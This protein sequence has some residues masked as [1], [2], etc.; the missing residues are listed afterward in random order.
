MAGETGGFNLGNAYGSVVIDVS[1]VTSAMR[2]AKDAIDRGLS[3]VGSAISSIGD[4]MSKL[5]GAI[6]TFSAPLA[7][8]GG[9]G[10]KAAA[11]F[12]TLMKQI[13]IFGNVAPSQMEKVSQFALK[14]GA[15]TKFS[16]ADAAAALLEL[17][18]S[19][20]SL[21]QAMQT[22]PDV[23]NLAATGNLDL[24][25][26][27]GIVSSALAIF[28]LKASDA[29]RVSNALAQAANATRA[30]VGDLGQGLSNVGPVA[31]QFGLSIE[32]TSAILG[33]FANN[34][35]MGAEAG[36][37]LK[38]MLLNMSRPTEKVQ[39]AFHALG[40]SLY[41][42]NGNAR[43]FNTVIK[44]LD[45]ALSKLPVEQ[46]N[47]LMQDLA[48][49]YG[50][51][52]L[53]ALRAAGGIDAT[54]EAMKNAPSAAKVAEA[55]MGTFK[56]QVES[57]TGSFETLMISAMT[58]FM[59][60]V[61]TPMVKQVI[62]VVNAMTEWTQK[63]PDLTKQ[64]VKVLGVVAV[65][66]P[67]LLV[68]GKAFSAIGTIIT[69]ATGPIGIIGALLYGLYQAFQTNFL[70]IRDTLQPIIDN[71][72]MGFETLIGVIG[73][74][75]DLVRD[76]GIGDAIGFIVNAFMQMLGLVKNDELSPAALS[77]GNGIVSAF[78]SVVGFITG[79]VLPTLGMVANWFINDALPAV[80]A[81]VQ[82]IA[83]PG[84]GA[85]FKF[86]GDIWAIVGPVLERLA[87][88][89]INDALPAVVGFIQNTVIPGIQNFINILL[90]VWNDVSPF[91]E[92]LANWFIND[93]LP[94]V[95]HYIED[96]VIVGI[97]KFID[98]L[99]GIW[100]LVKPTLDTLYNWFITEG[101][102]FINDALKGVVDNFIKPFVDVLAGIWVIVDPVLS[103]LKD[104]FVKDGL[105][106]ITTF[107]NDF[108]NN[109]ITPVI[110]VLKGIWD[111]V[112][113]ALDNLFKWFRDTFT[114]IKG[115]IQ[116]VLDFINDLIS[117]VT[118]AI[119]QLRQLGGGTPN[120]TSAQI[121]QNGLPANLPTIPGRDI[122]G[123]GMAGM[124]YQIGSGQLKNEVYIPGADGQ[125]VSGFVDLMKQVAASVGGQGSG[126]GDTF[127]IMMPEGALAN[128]ATARATGED[129]GRGVADGMRARGVKPL[130]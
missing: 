78:Q 96:V 54:L 39:D 87:N 63:N 83:I 98:V 84:I 114:Q 91:L 110:N 107:L 65:L 36:T 77:M 43:N 51:T 12:D 23:L 118:T 18:K 75:G 29:G 33:V 4:Q 105:P 47:M 53:N 22:L 19:G 70:G 73:H 46:Q 88:W 21:D 17:L 68:A 35:I 100:D 122:G 85:L 121:V 26:A 106:G 113:P 74:F 124:Q 128:P 102:P 72:V 20:Q 92:K 115:F 101:L 81:F 126:G 119:D 67:A 49:S 103:Q 58:P 62:E 129:F 97:Q 61:L 60:D 1:G 15:D 40:V 127:N 95:V 34:G 71:V 57:L 108:K 52:G 117:K 14:M 7:A 32:D 120:Q 93:V 125:F 44:E 130:R 89:F 116:P 27:S 48:G 45:S 111:A 9:I 104:W 50:I 3:G 94:V 31:A 69:I 16:S 41:D 42:S 37:Q 56:G 28:K 64:I 11:D 82:N 123:P 30:D 66:G 8:A 86:L 90:K 99:K 79:T 109:V 5:G 112:R 38:S 2:Q 76:N 24:A 6:S 25:R 80:V 59:N 10:L 13:E 55:F